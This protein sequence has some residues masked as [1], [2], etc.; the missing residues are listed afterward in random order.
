MK[1]CYLSYKTKFVITILTVSMA[2]LFTSCYSNYL[3][4]DYEV[5]WGAVWNDKHTK[6]AFVAS[7]RAYRNAEGI[8]AFPDGGRSLYLLEDVGLYVFDYENKLLDELITFS[9]LTSWLG[10]YRS[11]WHVTLALTDTMVYYLLS[12]VPD[13]DWQTEQARTHENLQYITSLKERYQQAYAFDMYTQNDK[14]VDSTAF[15]KLIIKSEK[16][17]LTSLYN[18]LEKIPL[19]DW[20]LKPAEIFPKSDEE[21]IEETIYLRNP[22][23][24]TRRAV[25]E[26]IIA[27]KSKAEIESLIKKMDNYKN[28]LEGSEKIMYELKSKDTYEQIKALL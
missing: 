25:V 2:F 14:I 7:K 16:C 20:D 9:D 5:H 6:V 10:T 8:A 21:Y 18:Q 19:T 24:K 3:T 26:Q 28:S 23:A 15:N 27:K 1:K 13:W 12:P 17:D 11:G 4:I 22:S